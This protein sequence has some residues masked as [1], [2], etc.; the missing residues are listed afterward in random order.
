M[1]SIPGIFSSL[2][3]SA[4]TALTFCLYLVHISKEKNH[5]NFGF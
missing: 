5:N 2:A 1:K 4:A 3:V